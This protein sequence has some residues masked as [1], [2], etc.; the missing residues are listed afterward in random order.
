MSDMIHECDGH[1][2]MQGKTCQMFVMSSVDKL[3][4]K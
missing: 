3:M 4:E 1:E 2:V